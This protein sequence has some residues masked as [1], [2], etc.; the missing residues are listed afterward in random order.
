MPRT[1]RA[2]AAN[3]CYHVLNRGNN[4][5]RVFH[6]D[7]DFDAFVGLLAEAKLRNPMPILAYCV[8]PNHKYVGLLKKHIVKGLGEQSD[9]LLPPVH[10]ALGVG[11]TQGHFRARAP[12]IFTGIRVIEVCSIELHFVF[13]HILLRKVSSNA[14][15]AWNR[16]HWGGNRTVPW[17]K[18]R[19]VKSYVDST[20]PGTPC[21]RR[22]FPRWRCP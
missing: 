22:R 10:G 9:S 21:P 16:V 2:S 7:G 14:S 5:A 6:K 20:C 17:S 15:Q 4:R 13:L 19:D 12:G 8:L 18:P 3:L 1:A 11:S